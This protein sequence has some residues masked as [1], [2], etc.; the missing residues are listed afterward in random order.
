MLATMLS[1]Y[2]SNLQEVSLCCITAVLQYSVPGRYSQ[3]SF[4]TM[5]LQW[6]MLDFK[7][8]FIYLFNQYALNTYCRYQNFIGGMKIDFKKSLL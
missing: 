4:K 3:A 8:S 5:P 7:Y 6:K 2:L 1:A